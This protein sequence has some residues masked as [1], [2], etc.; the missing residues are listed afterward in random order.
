MVPRTNRTSAFHGTEGP[1]LW[2]L[3]VVASVSF[4]F[5]GT[6]EAYNPPVDSASGVTLRIEGPEEVTFSPEGF[7]GA[8]VIENATDRPIVGNIEL[9][10]IDGFRVE[11]AELVDINVGP[12]E[13]LRKEFRV[14]PGPRVFNA[15]YPLHAYGRF[16][17]GTDQISL[18]PI[19]VFLVT[20]APPSSTA[21]WN[22]EPV[23]IGKGTALALDEWPIHRTIFQV[24]GNPSE[25]M[26][27]GWRG[28]HPVH[29]G[30]CE[31]LRITL[32]GQTRHAIAIHPP[33][34]QGQV[35]TA[36]IEFP[37]TLPT[38]TG[39][40][41]GFSLGLTPEGQ[42]DGVTFRVRVA[43]VNAPEGELGQ[44]VFERHTTAKTWETHEVDLTP[45][46]GRTVRLQ[47][48]SHPGPK[49]NTGWDSS[50]WGEVTI[51]GDKAESAQQGPTPPGGGEAIRLGKVSVG[52][53][54]GEVEVRLGRRGLLDAAVAIHFPE[55]R[56]LEFRG[57]E[58]TVLGSRLDTARSAA[59]LLGVHSQTEPRPDGSLSLAVTHRFQS[60][61]GPFELL[62]RLFVEKGVLVSR[63]DL[64]NVPAPRPW[65]HVHLEDVAIGSWSQPV[66]RV[67]AGAGNVIEK[68]GPYT[69]GFDGHR[70][71]TSF[72]GLEFD[73][74]L[75][76][77]QG[78]DV[79]PT[80]FVVNPADR[81]YSLHVA[82]PCRISLIAAENVW[83][84]AKT[85]RNVNGLKPSSGVP[86]LA[87]RFVFDLWSGRYRDSAEALQKAFRYGLTDSIVIWHNWQRWGY[88]YRLPEIFPP[89]PDLGTL[90]DMQFLAETC[91]QSG[92][93]FALHDNYIDFYP[94]AGGFSYLETIAFH[95]NGQ[96]VRAWF[97]EGR[98]AQSYRYRADRV[99]PFLRSNLLEIA[100]AI[101]PTAYFIDVWS[102]IDPYDYWTADGRFFD[103]VYT[104]NTWGRHFEWIRTLLGNNAPQ[105]SESGHDQLIGW[106]DG[107]TTN[108]LRVGKPIPGY[109]QWSVW[110]WEC[111]DAERVPWF[112]AAHHDRFALHGAGY[113][114]RYQ[115]GLD[116][117]LHGIYSDDYIT[118]E[119]L[120]GHPAMVPDPFGPDVV[121]KYWLLAPLGRALALDRIQE[122]EF[123]GGNIHRLHVR[124]ESGVETWCNRGESDWEVQGRV[125]PQYG[126]LALANGGSER[127]TIFKEV[128]ITKRDGL[129]VEF[130]QTPRSL[131]VNARKDY[132][133]PVP[134]RP[135][136][137]GFTQKGRQVEVN[138]VWS[139]KGGIRPG[140][141]P[142]AHFCNT[143]GEI[144][145]QGEVIPR[146]LAGLG[147]EV[148]T[149][150]RALVPESHSG[151]EELE[152]RVGLYRPRD[153]R[154]MSLAGPDDGQSRIRLGRLRSNPDGSLS[155]VPHP[156]EPDLALARQ[157]PEGRKVHFGAVATA[158][159]VRMSPED[160]G[161]LVLPLP[162]DGASTELTIFWSQL[163]WKLAPPT[164]AEYLDSDGHALRLEKVTDP[165]KVHLTIRPGEWGCRVKCDRPEG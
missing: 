143:S 130:C 24:F 122:V 36:A 52:R 78:C 135:R 48:E 34:Y 85:W 40:R 125:L 98:R 28:S 62:G 59:V 27:V 114:G 35:G 108:H 110:N 150:I 126:F 96:P 72:V 55:N 128:S 77:V 23:E 54:T 69:L 89:N 73:S 123:V 8:L 82:H 139:C 129:I 60:A 134:I 5:G 75:S 158:Q 39:V 163:P 49:N 133:G 66:R 109:Y 147:E 41:M 94:D 42:S 67:Y 88:D 120:T 86:L 37:V 102:S 18:H 31:R 30:S 152:L 3:P 65:I 87:G 13:K 15:H 137:T 46:A 142:F 165:A 33:W 148:G 7:G 127:A 157:N 83:E 53:L 63:W 17:G 2:L 118:T 56:V 47:L 74:G 112:D 159:G 101:K 106:L 38:S 115:A 145:F 117:R 21:R 45:F 107:A 141:V 99:E 51:F 90:E 149:T 104:R 76:V 151:N 119:V 6:A 44:V 91:R 153:G 156:D 162:V 164:E 22:W 136:A 131:Y 81:H 105:I 11:P 70:L 84:G 103:K 100:R 57:F 113:S 4:F 138:V 1:G 50:Y 9:R 71:S 116:A 161:L 12:K 10:S 160:G 26:P 43:E 32:G 25:T 80:S 111:A 155:W 93:L 58:V 19:L 146:D 140:W 97:N 29:R 16:R 154:R 121:R 124:W 79:P 20:G 144:I 132:T 14:L 68:P 64:A 95:G 92:V 61:A